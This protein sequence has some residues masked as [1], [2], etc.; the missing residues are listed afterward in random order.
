MIRPPYDLIYVDYHLLY[1][2][3]MINSLRW[4]IRA[5]KM[6]FLHSMGNK[7][8]TQLFEMFKLIYLWTLSNLSVFTI[9]F[10]QFIEIFSNV[11]NRIIIINDFPY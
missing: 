3:S 6:V 4:Q 1:Y 2:Y 7:W 8:A 9:I 5:I 10:N 11:K